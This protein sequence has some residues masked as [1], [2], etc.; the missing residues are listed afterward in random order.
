[1]C[2]W[3]PIG[4]A[5]WWNLAR[6]FPRPTIQLP[7]EWWTAFSILYRYAYFVGGTMARSGAFLLGDMVSRLAGGLLFGG[8]HQ[9]PWSNEPS[10]TQ[11]SGT[12][13][14]NFVVNI[15]GKAHPRQTPASIWYYAKS[16]VTRR[17]KMPLLVVFDLRRKPTSKWCKPNVLSWDEKERR[18]LWYLIW[19]KSRQV[20]SVCFVVRQMLERRE[21]MPL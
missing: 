1:M 8:S 21:R 3:K 10:F 6:I 7:G 4:L 5:V 12:I 17:E 20:C 11:Q 19:D 18:C 2:Q 14:W 13:C 9:C 16:I 15:F